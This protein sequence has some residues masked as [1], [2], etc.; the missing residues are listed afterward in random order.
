VIVEG[1][2]TLQPQ[3]VPH[4]DL[5]IYLD[6]DETDIVEWYTARFETLTLE[7]RSS[8]TGF[9]TRFAAQSPDQLRGTARYVWDLI[10]APNL[11]QCIAPTRDNADL[12]IHKRA[13]HSIA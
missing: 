11:H 2:N 5:R 4:L 8:G 13:D 6:A 1:V 3:F 7:A 10:N 12:V 9:Y